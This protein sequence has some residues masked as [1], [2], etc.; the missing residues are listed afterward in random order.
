[1]IT[2]GLHG[3]GDFGTRTSPR[4]PPGQR[5]VQRC[6]PGGVHFVAIG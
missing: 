6:V 3:A 1:M 2:A 5:S 4:T